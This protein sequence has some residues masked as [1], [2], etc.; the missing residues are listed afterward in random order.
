MRLWKVVSGALKD[1]NSLLLASFA[2]RTALRRPEIEAAVIRATT[3]D[4][5]PVDQ[6]CVDKVCHWIRLSPGANFRPVLWAIAARLEK[7]RSW[8]VALKALMLLHRVLSSDAA[9]D[10][11]G[12]LPFDLSGFSDSHSCP[13]KTWAQ[14]AF[15]RSY[16]AFLDQKSA[17]AS[18][19][20]PTRSASF[21]STGRRRG[22]QSRRLSPFNVAED[23]AAL[24]KL[25]GLLDVLLQVTPQQPELA[26]LPLVATAMDLVVFEVY[27]VYRLICSGVTKVLLRIYT[28]ERA[29]AKV[30]LRVMQ[31]AAVQGGDLAAFFEICTEL[32]LIHNLQCPKVKRI[33]EE[34]IRELEDIISGRTSP[35]TSSSSSDSSSGHV[36]TRS[37]P[38]PETGGGRRR[39]EGEGRDAAVEKG[40]LKTLI[41]TD[42]WETFDDDQPILE[43][44][45]P[46]LQPIA[47]R[48]GDDG[49]C[50]DRREVPDLISFSSL[51]SV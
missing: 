25:Q 6:R 27:D 46:L 17:T 22:E 20:N 12:R 36:K 4:E 37:N 41:I 5:F 39:R 51:L 1:H 44:T 32:G 2:T 31:K 21:G 26:A 38:S 49:N 35:S 43:S 40:G 28:A 48:G 11:I 18:R 45:P 10:G 24:E 47:V 42:R 16:F 30:A 14:N 34:D 15:V 29:E 7:T 23:L 3:H 8:V 33:P 19:T 50:C 9:P 13:E